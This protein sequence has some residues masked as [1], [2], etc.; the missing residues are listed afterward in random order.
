MLTSALHFN[1]KVFS[2]IIWSDTKSERKETTVVW[3]EHFYE[4]FTT[5]NNN[6]ED[7]NWSDGPNSE[8]KVVYIS[9]SKDLFAVYL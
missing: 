8:F 2:F 9:F 5:E 7:I 4:L 3:V 1:N 6:L